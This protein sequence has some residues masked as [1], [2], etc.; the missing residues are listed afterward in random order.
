MF[1]AVSGAEGIFLLG[2]VSQ[3]NTRALGLALLGADHC[4]DVW[5]A[6]AKSTSDS[7]SSMISQS[8]GR[9]RS[10]LELGAAEKQFSMT[11]KLILLARYR[12]I[13]C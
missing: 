12:S 11:K 3:V 6:V 1:I 8:A 10:I 2:Y 4:F 13:P 9:P 5:P 7:Q